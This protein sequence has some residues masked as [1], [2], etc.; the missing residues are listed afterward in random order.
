MQ[1]SE[2]YDFYIKINIQLYLNFDIYY[3]D[4]KA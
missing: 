3:T 4:H 2:R 1:K